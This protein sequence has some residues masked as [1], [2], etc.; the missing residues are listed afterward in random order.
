MINRENVLNV[1]ESYSYLVTK[2]D[3]LYD[4]S[5]MHDIVLQEWSLMVLLAPQSIFV[6]NC[7]TKSF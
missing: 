2:K 4:L 6:R 7:K 5:D 3:F 1:M